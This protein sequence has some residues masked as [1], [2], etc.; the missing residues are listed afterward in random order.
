MSIAAIVAH[1]DDAELGCGGWLAKSGGIIITCTNGANHPRDAE[2]AFEEQTRAAKFL[3]V[4]AF[5]LPFAEPVCNQDVVGAI[6]EILQSE[7]VST[8]C[9]HS[10][11]S[12]NSEH[13]V[14]NQIALAASRRIDNVL[15]ME[16]TPPDRGHVNPQFYVD[17]SDVADKKYRALTMHKSQIV[18]GGRNLV[19]T[20]R[21]L[22]EWRGHEIGVE[23]AEAVEVVRIKGD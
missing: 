18:R 13:R 20:R 19:T 2:T 4:K 7:A 12:E 22:D 17:I 9:T 16:P 10:P 11:A 14:V 1:P 5:I 23:K 8:A 15:Y 3:G 6:D 21:K